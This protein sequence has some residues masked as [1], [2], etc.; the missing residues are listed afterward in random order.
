MERLYSVRFRVYLK[1]MEINGG[2]Y[3]PHPQPLPL[4]GGESHAASQ[5]QAR[6]LI[7]PPLEGRG[8]PCGTST[9]NK[10][11]HLP[12]PSRGGVGGGVCISLIAEKEM[13]WGWGLYPKQKNKNYLVQSNESNTFPRTETKRNKD[14]KK[15]RVK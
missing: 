6:R 11:D 8:E 12:S 10:A 9:A 1:R 15:P 14:T 4:K 5:Q 2:S 3:R 7:S 13:G